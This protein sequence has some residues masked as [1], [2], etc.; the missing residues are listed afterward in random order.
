MVKLKIRII[1][2]LVILLM[3]G[4]SPLSVNAFA[5]NKVNQEESREILTEKMVDGKLKVNHYAL[6][7]DLVEED[8]QRILSMDEKMTWGYV[9]YKSY[10]AGIVIFDGKVS[11]LGENQWEVVE[12]EDLLD[13]ELGFKV[14]FS[15]FDVELEEN[16]IVVALMNFMIKNLESAQNI[17]ILQVEDQ[18]TNTENIIGSNQEFRNSI[19][20]K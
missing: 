12:N 14:I 10:N 9:N 2:V 20:V 6:P 5:E 3:L 13:V 7:N 8:L 4:T 16:V 11:K 15:G 17:K 1:G 19:S 18:T